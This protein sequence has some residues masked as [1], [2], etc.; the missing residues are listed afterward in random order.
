MPRRISDADI[1]ARVEYAPL[2]SSGWKR[3]NCPACDTR[4]GTPDTR[5]SF[6]VHMVSGRFLC[7]RCGFRGRLAR[8]SFDPLDE[9][10]SRRPTHVETLPEGYVP[11]ARVKDPLVLTY[12]A[13]RI[14][15]RWWDTIPCGFVESGHWAGYLVFAC[16][17]EGGGIEYYVGRKLPF[18]AA[19]GPRYRYPAVPRHGALFNAPALVEATNRP[20][21]I[22]EGIFDAAALWPDAVATLGKDV[23]EAVVKRLVST[24]R[25]LVVAL[26]GDAVTT[27]WTLALQLNY[28]GHSNVH[29]VQ[30]PR[31][32]DP[33][34][35]GRAEMERLPRRRPH[36]APSVRM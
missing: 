26:D 9:W 6:G 12:V 2:S 23:P 8:G 10:V 14:E 17:D 16:L 18:H 34:S 24:H 30:L 15:E 31:E 29:W 36:E 13:G 32:H 33:S 3:A 1:L 35:L 5:R 21:Y 25:P 4:V 11:L 28:L 19:G 20:L 22:V 7:F 27:A